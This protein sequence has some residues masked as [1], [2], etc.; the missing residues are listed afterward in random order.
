VV[1]VVVNE[2]TQERYASS[3][4]REANRGKLKKI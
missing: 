2:E 4:E 3:M 1:V